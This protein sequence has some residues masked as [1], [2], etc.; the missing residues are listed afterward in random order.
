[1]GEP[2]RNSGKNYTF[3]AWIYETE[4]VESLD[5]NTSVKQI[6]ELFYAKTDKIAALKKQYELYVSV[7]VCIKIENGEPPAIYFEPE[8]IKFAAEIGAHIDVDTYVN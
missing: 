1:M 8:F 7:D 5:I 4:S 6:E 2:I 3:T